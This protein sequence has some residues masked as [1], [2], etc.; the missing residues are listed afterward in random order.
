MLPVLSMLLH[1]DGRRCAAR[2]SLR[3]FE[4][5]PGCS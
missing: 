4:D 2:F 1:P 3:V 5:Y